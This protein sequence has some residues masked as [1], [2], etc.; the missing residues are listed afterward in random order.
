MRVILGLLFLAATA[1]AQS[2]PATQ[3]K[4]DASASANTAPELTIP[5]GTKV[6]VALKH[7]VSSKGTHEGD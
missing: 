1:L 5:S 3:P 4:A 6:P 2:S 7:A